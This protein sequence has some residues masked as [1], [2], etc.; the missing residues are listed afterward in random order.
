MEQ[1]QGAP[2]LSSET[3]NRTTIIWSNPLL[4]L[5]VWIAASF[6]MA[7]LVLAWE[8]L[9]CS[10]VLPS[11]HRTSLTRM[12]QSRS[13]SS[14]GQSTIGGLG[15]G[16]R[17]RLALDYLDAATQDLPSY[18]EVLVMHRQDRVARWKEEFQSDQKDITALEPRMIGSMETLI[19]SLET[20]LKLQTLARNYDWQSIQE[21][22]HSELLAS[23]MEKAASQLRVIMWGYQRDASE[24]I[25]FDWGS[26]GWRHCGAL[27]D[28]QE[29]LDELDHLLGV[30]EP[31]EALFCL[32][33]VE[34]SIRDMLNGLPWK[35][36]T[37]NEGDRLLQR[38]E[39]LGPYR[40][41][42]SSG[43]DEG[44]L[45]DDYLEALRDLRID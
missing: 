23:D 19:D 8:D 28:A 36:L 33:I 26:C 6:A 3:S 11:R 13:L 30:L 10:Y 27:A 38:Y 12:A 20:I 37:G 18:N 31:P 41:Y 15:F 25:G 14:F 7:L 34:R 44:G 35:R 42:Q 5:S 21:L 1:N 29:A 16:E 45:E 4:S 24:T 17:D 43:A 22:L 2:S 40:P 32:D 39:S 9:T